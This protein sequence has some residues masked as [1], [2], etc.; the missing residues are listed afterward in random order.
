MVWLFSSSCSYCLAGK[1]LV[2]QYNEV[3][4]TPFFQ[5]GRSSLRLRQLPLS[6]PAGALQ[7]AA[8]SMMCAKLPHAIGSAPLA[9]TSAKIGSGAPLKAV[10]ML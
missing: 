5:R 6:P 2:A 9:I 8:M 1:C 3:A 7:S 4:T 10:G